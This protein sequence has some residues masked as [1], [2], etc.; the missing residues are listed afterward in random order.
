LLLLFMPLVNDGLSPTE[1]RL[2][3]AFALIFIVSFPLRIYRLARNRFKST[4]NVGQEKFWAVDESGIEIRGRSFFQQTGWANIVRFSEDK[5][6]FFIWY[7]NSEYSYFLKC[8]IS[9]SQLANIRQ[10]FFQNGKK[11]Y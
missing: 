7:N 3:M 4:P 10:L 8:A 11:G 2:F 1:N 5:K 9:E 6:V